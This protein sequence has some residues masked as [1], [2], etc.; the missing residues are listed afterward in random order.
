M[1]ELVTSDADLSSMVL[2]AAI[3]RQAQIQLQRMFRDPYLLEKEDRALLIQQLQLAVEAAPDTAELRVLLGM[4]ECVDFKIQDGLETLREAVKR[5]PD[6][7]LARL[8]F[9]ELL[10]RLRI[11]DQAVEQ[12]REAALLA[13]N[14]VQSELARRQAA[15]LRTLLQQG[16]ERDVSLSPR[17]VI[18]RMWRQ[19]RGKDNPGIAL[20]GPG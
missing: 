6:S 13:A 15:T 1:S 19:V 7:F 16:I 12:T 9:G 11:C 18:A 10:M 17:R 4:V 14:P 2:A 3:P 8:K 20:I 5:D